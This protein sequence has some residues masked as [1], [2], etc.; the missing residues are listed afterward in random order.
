MSSDIPHRFPLRREAIRRILMSTTRSLCRNGAQALRRPSP[1]R[2]HISASD[3]LRSAPAP[4]PKR[5]PCK[6]TA[7]CPCNSR[8]NCKQLTRVKRH[9]TSPSPIHAARRLPRAP[10]APLLLHLRPVTHHQFAFSSQGAI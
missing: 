3:K 5:L 9:P 6:I 8:C 2:R 10:T 7:P 1:F 4:L